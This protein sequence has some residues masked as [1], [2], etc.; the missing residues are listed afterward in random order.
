MNAPSK[1]GIAGLIRFALIEVLVVLIG[2]VF[3]RR[4]VYMGG[5]FGEMVL[6]WQEYALLGLSFIDGLVRGQTRALYSSPFRKKV[7]RYF[8]PFALFLFVACSSLC[9]KLNVGCVREEWFRDLGLCIMGGGVILLIITQRTRPAALLTAN[10]VQKLPGT[11]SWEECKLAEA[12]QAEAH[13]DQSTQTTESGSIESDL[14]ASLDPIGKIDPEVHD[15]EVQAQQVYDECG[16]AFSKEESVL[17]N[18]KNTELDRPEAQRKQSIRKNVPDSTDD[19][20][21]KRNSHAGDEGDNGQV[22]DSDAIQG[23]WRYLR[24]PSRTAIFLELVGI[25]M[26][27][28]AWMP[29]FTLPGLIIL[30]KWEL[31]DLEAFRISQFG[32]EYVRYKERTWLLVPFLY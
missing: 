16:Q 21:P 19:D 18:E 15:P 5:H 24:Y 31:A 10:F 30:F 12:A 7:L 17:S 4:E 26:A 11:N 23:P 14:F 29:I 32:A 2:M 6:H 9:D 28:S 1:T 13:L 8:L 22:F 3:V 27:L 25:S 20:L